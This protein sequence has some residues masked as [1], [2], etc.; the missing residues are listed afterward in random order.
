VRLL[1]AIL[2]TVSATARANELQ[3]RIDAAAPGTTI[4]VGPGVYGPIKVDKPIKLV[5]TGWPVI[6]G[7][8][9][10]DCVLM[11]GGNSE[12]SGFVIRNSGSDLDRESCGLR[13]MGAST[14]IQ[15]NRFENVLF[16]VDLKQAPDC[17]IRGNVIGSMPLEIARRGDALRL[18]RSDRCVIEENI[19]EDG[20]DSLMWYSDKLTIR[21]NVSRRNRYGFHMMFAND[22]TLEDNDIAD[23]S[24]GIYLMY[25]RGFHVRHNRITRSR[26]PSGYGIGFKEVDQ[27]DISSNVLSGNRVA[28]YLDGSPMTR[29][30]GKAFITGNAIGCNDIGLS[31]LPAVKGNTIRDNNVVDNIEQLAI[32]G[33]G[34][35]GGN[36]IVGNY[37]SDYTGYDRNRDGT[38]DQPYESRKLFESLIDT[39]PKLRLLIYSPAHDAIEFIG[40]AMPAVRPET[41]FSDPAPRM[42]PIALNLPTIGAS[43]HRSIAWAALGLLSVPA[44]VGWLLWLSGRAR[45]DRRIGRA[46]VVGVSTTG[47]SGTLLSRRNVDVA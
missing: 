34:N 9:K 3:A 18:F 26:G 22:V 19:I 14:V 5:G 41:R 37:W 1:L 10:S 11:V 39:N 8:G 28:I 2:L 21:R 24:V 13:V 33:R 32:Q 23:N 25:G 45:H 29:R 36:E 6:D 42:K 30:P 16:G 17:V 38:G 44:V 46:D 20:R 35:A 43:E 31:F 12:I 4:A 27:Y 40:K 7:G 47:G 15:H